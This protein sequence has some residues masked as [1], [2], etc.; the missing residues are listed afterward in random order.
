MACQR[1]AL[2]TSIAVEL[3]GILEMNRSLNRRFQERIQGSNHLIRIADWIGQRQVVLS[4]TS[5][6]VDQMRWVTVVASHRQSHIETDA[7]WR[8]SIESAMQRCQLENLALLVCRLTPSGDY[9]LHVAKRVA[10]ATVEVMMPKPHAP[11]ASW[12]AEVARAS[13]S[14]IEENQL[15]ISPLPTENVHCP[16]IV[17]GPLPDLAMIAI[18][19][20][21]HAV[22]VNKGGRIDRLLR[23]R[24]ACGHHPI[25]SVAVQLTRTGVELKRVASNTTVAREL[26]ELGAVGWY[27]T[28][29][30]ES[31]NPMVAADDTGIFSELSQRT[32]SQRNLA[33]TK[34]YS[35]VFSKD[36]VRKPESVLSLIPNSAVSQSPSQAMSSKVSNWTYL[37]HCT[38]SPSGPWPDQSRSGYYDEILTESDHSHPIDTLIRILEQQRL[39][40][41]NHLKRSKVETV[42]LS[43]VPLTEL[44]S[45]HSFQRHLHRWDWEPYGI[46][47]QQ[48]WLESR[49]CRPVVYGGEADLQKLQVEN[50]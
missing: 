22:E 33:S 1:T 27:R 42:S 12:Q 34:A 31:T 7:S 39:V 4:G 18:A 25:G 2:S 17:E 44:L 46:C 6:R 16:V 36:L 8:E 41:S 11:L 20:L 43:Q 45:R 23:H 19:D 15:W 28:S 10:I 30:Y 35:P 21:V 32:L 50:N 49:G 38:R 48:Q 40:G 24:L 26:M 9:L 3:F 29:K 13:Q 47:I 14:D 37:T 5:M